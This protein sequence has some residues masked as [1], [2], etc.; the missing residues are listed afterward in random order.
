MEDTNFLTL[1]FLKITFVKC[2]LIV[3]DNK[4]KQTKSIITQEEIP[5]C[6]FRWRCI[7]KV[8][9]L[10]KRPRDGLPIIC[11]SIGQCHF[12]YSHLY[13]LITKSRGLIEGF[14]PTVC[15]S[16]P[17]GDL[18]LLFYKMCTSFSIKSCY[19]TCMG[20]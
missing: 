19:C 10:K 7:L 12:L 6:G 20:Y 1:N 16:R 14:L 13:H 4:F 5:R 9:P 2:F 15:C 11:C 18:R 3:I 17:S 8:P